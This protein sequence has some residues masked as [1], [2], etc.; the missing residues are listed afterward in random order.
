[1]TLYE[2]TVANLLEMISD[3]KGESQTDTSAKRLRFLSFRERSLAKRKLWKLFILP[4]QTATGDG[5]ADYTVGSTTNPMRLNGLSEVFVGGTT[6][7]KQYA[8]ID[9][10]KFKELYNQSNANKVCYVWYD[11]ANK[12]W[13]MHL[14]PAPE[15]GVTITYSYFW[16]PPKRT[17]TADYVYFP[18]DEALARLTLGDIY[19]AEDEPENAAEQRNMGEQIIS[20]AMGQDNAPGVNQL[21]KFEAIENMGKD[22]GIGSY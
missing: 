17:T 1:M 19:E 2:D 3:L 5:T 8:I 16:I 13:K 22:R 6:A 20:E 10:H 14:N 15:T 21:I 7:D 18:D 4:N 11:A 12:L 9:Y